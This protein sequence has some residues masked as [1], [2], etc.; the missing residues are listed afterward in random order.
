MK[1]TSRFLT[2]LIAGLLSLVLFSCSKNNNLEVNTIPEELF[3][4]WT[5]RIEETVIKNAGV[6]EKDNVK[7]YPEDIKFLKIE[8]DGTYSIYTKTTAPSIET[9]TTLEQ[10]TWEWSNGMITF[11]NH[12]SKDESGNYSK[13][14][15]KLEYQRGVITLV[16]ELT[17]GAYSY[18]YKA[19]LERVMF[20]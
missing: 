16:D 1:H 6:T 17:D 15:Y 8:N 2:I 4:V 13:G 10:G 14:S 11:E 3:D 12:F 5:Y 20:K 19:E 18:R 9:T 7:S